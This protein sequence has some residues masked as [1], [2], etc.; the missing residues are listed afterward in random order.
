MQLQWKIEITISRDTAESLRYLLDLAEC[1]AVG[2]HAWLIQ[3]VG[4]V[5]GAEEMQVVHHDE[6][7]GLQ[8]G[9][10]AA[11]ASYAEYGVVS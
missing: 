11:Q 5:V 7:R 10:V 1:G 3:D 2:K 8:V 9:Q 4:E 6:S